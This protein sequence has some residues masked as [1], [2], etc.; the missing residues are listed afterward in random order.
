M[1]KNINTELDVTGEISESENLVS[2]NESMLEEPQSE[3]DGFSLIICK[4]VRKAT[5]R[6]SLS[7]KAT[8]TK[9][10]KK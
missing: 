3:S 10:S 5:Q 1:I 9:S 6:L 2:E 8:K 4:R 7:G